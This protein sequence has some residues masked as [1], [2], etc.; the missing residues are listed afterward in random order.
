MS[1]ILIS[2][3]PFAEYDN[4]PLKLLNESGFEYD[5]NPLKRKLNE[6]ELFEII[7]N[8]DSVIAGTEPFTEKVI[9]N[10]KKLRHISRVGSGIN[11]IDL[12]LAKE[13]KITISYTPDAPINA[14]AEFT[15]GLF[16]CSLR[17]I[18]I[19]NQSMTA[20]CKWNRVMGRSI[21]E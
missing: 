21:S 7:T 3:Y 11:S 15:I 8:Y 10:A 14:V 12:N 2:I 20:D 16:L 19:S 9:A 6:E 13:K 1:K 18:H 5:V 17:G 4:T